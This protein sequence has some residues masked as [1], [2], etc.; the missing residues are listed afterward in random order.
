MCKGG[1]KEGEKERRRERKRERLFFLLE[2]IKHC[3][4]FPSPII[5]SGNIPLPRILTLA[6]MVTFS[7]SSVKMLEHSSNLCH[8]NTEGEGFHFS[9]DYGNLLLGESHH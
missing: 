6:M 7:A 9:A 3:S 1:W 5:V 8:G 2:I 4:S